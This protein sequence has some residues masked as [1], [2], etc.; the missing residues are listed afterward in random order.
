MLKKIEIPTGTVYTL[1]LCN[2]HFFT[3]AQRVAHIHKEHAEKGEDITDTYSRK[4]TIM[5]KTASAGGTEEDLEEEPTKTPPPPKKT[6]VPL[7]P[8]TLPPPQDIRYYKVPFKVPH[9]QVEGLQVQKAYSL[10]TAAKTTPQ[11]PKFVVL[12][13]K[14]PYTIVQRPNEASPNK[15]YSRKDQTVNVSILL[16]V[17]LVNVTNPV[18]FSVAA[19]LTSNNHHEETRNRGTHQD[20]DQPNQGRR[21]SHPQQWIQER[22]RRTAKALEFR[23]RVIFSD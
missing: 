10:V 2:E 3:S 11:P 7:L 19:S 20:R 8:K 13:A 5:R 1:Q 9:S 21:P 18:W 22:K 12:P 6:P 16:S 17:Y 4:D 23:I 15:T 14:Q